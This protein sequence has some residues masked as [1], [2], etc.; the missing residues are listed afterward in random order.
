MTA[1]HFLIFKKNLFQV[2]EEN[3]LG[4]FGHGYKYAIGILNEG[5]IGI[6]SQVSEN[7]KT[8][9]AGCLGTFEF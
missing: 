9:S 5:R 3:I 4:T 6:G 1:P 2:P 7:L 8:N